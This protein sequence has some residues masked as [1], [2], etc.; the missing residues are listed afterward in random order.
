MKNNK[1]VKSMYKYITTGVYQQTNFTYRVR[2]TVNGERITCTF[3]N[4]A[5]AIKY[6]NSFK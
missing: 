1:K 5:K 2:K 3:T 6:Y 4:K